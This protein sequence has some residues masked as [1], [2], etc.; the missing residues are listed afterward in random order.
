MADAGAHLRLELLR[1]P[2][3][4]LPDRRL[5]LSR[6]DAALLAVL[7]MDGA[8][9]RDTLAALLWP[10]QDP[11]HARASLR[12]R[13][14]RLARG[15]GAPIVAGDATLHLAAGVRHAL[16]QPALLLAD[17]VQALDGDLL[18][19][20][21]YDDCPAFDQWLLGARE[22]WRV[23]RAQALARVASAFEARREVAAALRC[24]E[25]LAADEPLSDHAHRRLMRLHYL[26]GDLG[27]ALGVYRDF[28]DRLG[29]ELGELPDDE[30]A[31]L[32]ATLRK[33]ELPARASAPLPATLARPPRLVGRA[34]AWAALET[35]W[36]ERR[37]LVVEGAPGLG[38]T[39]LVTDFL[40]SRHGRPLLVSAQPGDA[41]HP[42]ALLARLLARLWAR[43]GRPPALEEWAKRELACLL[44]ELGPSPERA[45]TLRL[46]RAA[47]SALAPHALSLVVLDDVQQADVATLEMLPALVGPDL[48]LW[49]MTVRVGEHPPPLAAWMQ[50]SGGPLAV[51]LAPLVR[52]DVVV[53]LDDLAL[54]TPADAV[55]LW[56]YTGGNPL[57]LLETLRSLLGSPGSVP[58]QD[59]PPPAPAAQVV[60]SRLA[61]LDDAA[62]QLA[63]AGAVL[64]GVVTLD[65]AAAL[66]GADVG[67]AAAGSA[68]ASAFA[69]L[70][71]EQWLGPDG[72][73]H[74]LV[75]AALRAEMPAALRRWLS[76]RAAALRE[77]Q[78]AGSA[79]VAT[80]WQ[81]AGRDALAAAAFEAAARQAWQAS[82][83]QEE[84]LLWSHAA[85]AWQ[86]AGERASAFRARRE[87]L[88]ARLFSQGPAGARPVADRLL[89]DAVGPAERAQALIASAHVHV[90][91]GDDAQALAPAR[92]ALALATALGD[93]AG[94][95]QAACH[96]ASALAS[97]HGV[98]EALA[99]LQAQRQAAES[100]PMR[101]RHHYLSQLSYV[102]YRGSRLT[103]C[104][105]VLR[106]ALALAE[107]EAYWTEASTNASNMCA[108][109][110]ALG[111]FDEAW[112]AAQH[113]LALRDRLGPTQGV[114][115]GGVDLYAGFALLGLGRI[116]EA[117][118]AF[119]RARGHYVATA[120]DG[121]W[122]AQAEHAMARA[123]LLRGDA[124]AAAAS[125]GA[126][127]SNATPA[128]RARRQALLARIAEA[129]GADT[130][131]PLAAARVLLA[132]V[133]GDAA[134]AAVEAEIAVVDARA[135]GD[136]ALQAIERRMRADEQ[137][138]LAQ[139]LA[140]A[141][142]ERLLDAGDAAAAALAEALCDAPAQPVD[143]P[144]AWRRQ[145]LRSAQAL[146][147]TRPN[148]VATR[149]TAKRR[150]RG[151]G[152][153][154]AR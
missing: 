145:L 95:V 58:L 22:R 80:L 152:A 30:T 50:A 105:G 49:W 97:T 42:Y 126:L 96:L 82:R 134:R 17:D 53:L 113:A 25:R 100:G 154:L 118:D 132:A 56:D 52:D 26:R 66:I 47:A 143:L 19:G 117:I 129:H 13:R 109:L 44:P 101:L 60:R 144:P 43:D 20:F 29:A 3:L 115:P 21:V 46:Q 136:D 125:L 35:A 147:A 70:E 69:A 104:T 1:D 140:W 6:K 146:R 102:L 41:S 139:R 73:M 138:A 112:Q 57:F 54:D 68:L 93:A 89:A 149:A 11:A 8:C 28:A 150:R 37:P 83:P 38:K 120:S 135:I 148:R 61:R 34:V 85:D 88:Q 108:L 45:D 63:R 121:V 84:A 72:H 151:D 114:Q 103:A 130:R 71:A 127:P 55:A 76:G 23:Q 124:D 62:V 110:N 87:G 75:R 78:G 142:V 4:V 67:E 91:N 51:P 5:P 74:D 65:D 40:A 7:A 153:P 111:R 39:R 98:E 107:S 9:A 106:E 90:V 27:A 2:G 18:D 99:V 16:A 141:R 10:V 59:R 14:F 86:R 15:A 122:L 133:A 137:H 24:A 48:P 12:Q 79:V 32:A 119:G 33:G 77:R 116:D 81:D 31:A 94:T 64:S 128:L 131:A 36:A 123:Q 92:E